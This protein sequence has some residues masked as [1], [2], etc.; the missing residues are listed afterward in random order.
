MI[1]FWFIVLSISIRYTQ[2]WCSCLLSTRKVELYGTSCT[3]MDVATLAPRALRMC[4]ILKF[5]SARRIFTRTSPCQAA[6]NMQWLRLCSVFCCN[7]FGCAQRHHPRVVDNSIQSN[8][9]SLGRKQR[10]LLLF[11]AILVS[12]ELKSSLS[13]VCDCVLEMGEV[14]G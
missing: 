6:G 3:S 9:A 14:T 10:L 7:Q 2:W 12:P 8:Y 11:Q 4:V 13:L 5:W 1:R